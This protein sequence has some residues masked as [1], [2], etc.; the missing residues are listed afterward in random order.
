M[1]GNAA[2]KL[3]QRGFGLLL[4]AD[5]DEHVQ[6]QAQRLRLG[7]RHIALDHAAR[8][9]RLDPVQAGRRRQMHAPGQLHIGQRTVFLQL[10]QYFVIHA[11]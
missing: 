11:V 2:L 9:Q 4:Q 5:G 6:P 8:L 3:G 1:L 10:R 7:E